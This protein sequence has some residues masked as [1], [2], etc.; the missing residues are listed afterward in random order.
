MQVS[1][2]LADYAQVSDGKLT[3]VG[4]GWSE[5]GPH[6]P[7]GVGIV[8]KVAWTETNVQHTIRLDLIDSDGNEVTVETPEGE[9]GLFVEHRFNVG[10]PPTVKP[11]TTLS[12]VW[13]FNCT[14]PTEAGRQY[15]WRVAVDGKEDGGLSPTFTVRPLPPAMAA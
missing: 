11:G 8:A 12:Y 4:V 5:T 3:L 13:G 9:Q 1:V 10:R 15:E 14:P 6:V 2:L 7:H